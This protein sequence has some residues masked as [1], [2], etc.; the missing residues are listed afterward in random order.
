[1][2]L[3]DADFVSPP[4]VA[5][6]T[7]AFFNGQIDL[8]PASSEWAN[9]VIGAQRFFTPADSGLSQK[10]KAKSVYLFPPRDVLHSKEQPPETLLYV[11][12][13]RFKKSAQ[14]VWLEEAI[15][16][17]NRQE[18]E[19]AIVFITS[20]DVAL[21]C[22]QKLDI[23]L[24]MCVMKERPELY[25]DTKELAKMPRTKCYGFIFYIP[26]PYNTE[27][28]IYEFSAMFSGLG[29]VYT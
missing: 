6:T 13:K 21:L 9:T 11:R 5:G 29:R 26:S 18:Y 7:T 28:R 22:T 27:K 1:M 24:P 14:R 15:R 2:P 16:K 12:R 3:A 10:W 4:D 25:T 20:S 8:D 23:D 19:E 17:Y